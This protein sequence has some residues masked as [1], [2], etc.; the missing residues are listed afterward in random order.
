MKGVEATKEEKS[1]SDLRDDAEMEQTRMWGE[2]MSGQS[3]LVRNVTPRRQVG[4]HWQMKSM[5][6]GVREK[7]KRVLWSPGGVG[8]PLVMNPSASCLLPT[9]K[10]V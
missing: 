8:D 7:L 1:L 9:L 10:E 6:P 4:P 3:V 5:G 2:L